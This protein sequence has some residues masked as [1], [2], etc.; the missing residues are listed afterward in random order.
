[1][2]LLNQNVFRCEPDSRRSLPEVFDGLSQGE[3]QA[4][5]ALRP[6]QR[7]AWH[8][9]L[10][11]LGV[12]AIERTNWPQSSQE[13]ADSLRSLTNFGDD[14]WSLVVTDRNRPAFMQPSDPG[15]LNWSTVLTPD[16]LDML[17][18]AKNHDVKSRIAVDGLQTT[19]SLL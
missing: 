17:I 15:G 13:W 7:A 5:T 1:M 18:T 10:V 8:M 3:I 2:N 19:G 4:F 14:A 6:H 12:L 11:Q 9:F 16:A